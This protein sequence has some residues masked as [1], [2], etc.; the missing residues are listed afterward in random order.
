MFS[1]K[2][3]VKH[4]GQIVIFVEVAGSGYKIMFTATT[5]TDMDTAKRISISG[6]A[7]T[8]NKV[9]YAYMI[10]NYHKVFQI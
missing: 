6:V 2:K 7:R 1:I 10:G 5:S 3:G 9:F 4:C 8:S